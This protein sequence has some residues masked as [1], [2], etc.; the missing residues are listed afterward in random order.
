MKLFYRKT[1]EINKNLTILLKINALVTNSFFS[2]AV[3]SE[4]PIVAT[5]VTQDAAA[6]TAMMLSDLYG[7]L[8]F[9]EEAVGDV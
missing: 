1:I 5:V 7:K 2:S 9:A 6:L 3:R 8:N 4:D